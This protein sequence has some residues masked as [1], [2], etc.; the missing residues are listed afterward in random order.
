MQSAVKRYYNIN[1]ILMSKLGVWSTQSKF[2]KILLPI[3]TTSFLFCIGFLE[4]N[5]HRF[6]CGVC[7]CKN[8]YANKICE[9]GKEEERKKYPHVVSMWFIFDVIEE[10]C[11]NFA[12]SPFKFVEIPKKIFNIYTLRKKNLNI[13]VCVRV[14]YFII[15]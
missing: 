11:I 5:S 9:R 8:R 3:V 7:P 12:K 6:L 4:V 15:D 14:R 10:V 13:C 2:M 1:K